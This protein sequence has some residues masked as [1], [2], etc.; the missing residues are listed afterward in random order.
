MRDEEKKD[1]TEL[2]LN[3]EMRPE[4]YFGEMERYFDKFYRHPF[5]IMT[6]SFALRDL[7]EFGEIKPTVD[8]FEEGTDFVVKAE[9]PGMKK[10]DLNVMITENRITISGEKDHLPGASGCRKM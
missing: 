3:E 4:T 9:L 7:P 6:P 10:E 8:I 1:K 2:T 5:S